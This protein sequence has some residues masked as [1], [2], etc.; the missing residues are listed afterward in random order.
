MAY[1]LTLKTAPL[2]E[3]ISL[4]E[5]KAHLRVDFDDDDAVIQSMIRG[6]RSKLEWVYNVSFLTQSLV[7][8][9][10]RFVQPGTPVPSYGVP[11]VG[12][13]GWGPGGLNRWGWTY[14][15]WSVIELRPPLQSITSIKYTD[16]SGNPQTL[17]PLVYAI[18][19]SWP[20]RVFPNV[21]KIWPVTAL[22][23]G[24]IQIEFISGHTGPSL[25]PDNMRSAVQLTIGAL[26][27]NREQYVIG[28]RLVAV[29][30]P[31]GVADLMG[32]YAPTL[33]R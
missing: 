3:P 17:D 11:N 32:A 7:L 26:Y 18:D 13:F 6:A 15:S 9:L 12:T 19:K 2:V 27:E 30:L 8:G 23:P 21:N 1:N 20:G 22:L 14:P 5:A 33:I 28:T 24:A 4:A 10:D 29:E 31:E 25:V 16:P